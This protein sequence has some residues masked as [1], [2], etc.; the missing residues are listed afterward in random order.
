MDAVGD[1]AGDTLVDADEIVHRCGI[2]SEHD[3][4]LACIVLHALHEHLDGLGGLGILR[5]GIVDRGE[6][7][8]LVDEEQLA[9]G[10]VAV[11]GHVL[12][13]TVLVL[14]HDVLALTL[15]DVGRGEQLH[16]V[17]DLAELAGH[18]GLARAGV[19]CQDDVELHR[20]LGLQ[21][22]VETLIHVC[23]LGGYLAHEVLDG[24]HAH[25]VAVELCHN[26]ID[27]EL[28]ER[29]GALDVGTAEQTVLGLALGEQTLAVALQGTLEGRHHLTGV[30]EVLRAALVHLLEELA[31]MR[32]GVGIEAVVLLLEFLAEDM[33]ELLGGVVGELQPFVEAG[34]DAG[35]GI[36][37]VEHLLGI[38]C[39]DT[40][41]LAAQLLDGLQQRV[42]SLAPVVATLARGEGV[43]LVDEEHAAHGRIDHLA[44]LRC[45]AADVLR[46]QVLARDL[47][48]LSARQD[49]EAAEH[50]GKDAGHGG[51]ARA[52][53]AEEDILVL[54]GR[55]RLGVVFLKAVLLDILD[56]AKHLALHVVD[57]HECIKT[58]QD[59]V[60]CLL[61]EDVARDI[62]GLY[63]TSMAVLQTTLVDIVGLLHRL[64]GIAE[65][66][67]TVLHQIAEIAEELLLG[68]ALAG[69][70]AAG[71]LALAD[72]EQLGWRAVVELEHQGEAAA[73]ALLLLEVVFYLVFLT[74]E[75]HDRIGVPVGREVALPVF[76]HTQQTVDG[77]Q[78]LRVGHQQMGIVDDDQTAPQLLN[79][80]L[81]EG[82][83]P[84]VVG[85]GIDLL[86]TRMGD[87]AVGEEQLVDETDEE[88]LARAAVAE[89]EHIHLWTLAQTTLTLG[90]IIE[91]DE[92]LHLIDDLLLADG[93][94]EEDG[95]I[96]SWCRRWGWRRLHCRSHRC[97]VRYGGRWC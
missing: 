37:E 65:G 29:V 96:D 80:L 82:A 36:E 31:D 13:R 87:D 19:T 66:D 55:Q 27:V 81:V 58:T 90:G 45:R 5:A 49:A 83:Y 25:E 30:A 75:D 24:L 38:A 23:L 67:L 97:F 26:L 91:G 6:A 9:H 21:S 51:L 3:S 54:E 64:V 53:V 74:F 20:L 60:G 33:G 4:E 94:C 41:E 12:A 39:D 2:A 11:L 93:I 72:G 15:D 16:G 86:D 76:H 10:E 57:T 78:V 63:L 56:D 92:T 50:I 71:E 34:G 88:G 73:T 35:V 8:G 1:A 59:L 77:C 32:L 7:V 85:R 68:L 28:T 95:R 48:E 18:G 22:E 70:S 84:L 52:G 79:G 69:Q 47:D 46:H 42:D 14:A 44:R 62:L 40:D 17:E 43:G 61:N 89:H